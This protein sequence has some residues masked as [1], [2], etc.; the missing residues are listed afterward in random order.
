MWSL[1]RWGANSETG[2]GVIEGGVMVLLSTASGG[3]VSER[4]MGRVS[5]KSQRGAGLLEVVIAIGLLGILLT[6]FIPAMMGITRANIKVDERE[7]AKNLA[8]RQMEY[9]KGQPFLAAYVPDDYASDYPG[10]VVDNPI[11]TNSSTISNR[12][13]DI[14]AV[15]VIVRLHGV[16][17]IRLTGYKVR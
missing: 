16:E 11:T 4:T 17:V 3:I 6:G 14:Q 8:E 1:G 7:T 13:A 15:T 2:I 12:D 5:M 10:F 9:V